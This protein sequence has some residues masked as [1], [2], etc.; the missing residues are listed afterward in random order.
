MRHLAAD[1]LA[2]PASGEKDPDA[3]GAELAALAELGRRTA[4]TVGKLEARLEGV[5]TELSRLVAQVERHGDELFLPLMD[6]LDAL[7]AALWITPQ[8]IPGASSVAAQ[9]GRSVGARSALDRNAAAIAVGAAYRARA[10]ASA[11]TSLHVS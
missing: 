1:S 2:G 7:E 6:A 10:R 5:E 4:R 3:D 11:R 9:R 8:H